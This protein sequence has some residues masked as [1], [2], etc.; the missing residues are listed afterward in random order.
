MS[1]KPLENQQILATRADNKQVA[2]C[3]LIE[4]YGAKAVALPCIDI[5]P[6]TPD[7]VGFGIAKQHILDLD[8]FDIVICISANAARIAGELIDQYWPQLP[9]KIKWLAIGSASAKELAYFDIDAQI[10]PGADSESLLAH[11]DLQ[12]VANQKVLILQGNSGRELLQQSLIERGAFISQAILY[13]RLIP[14]YT[15]QQVENSLYKSTISA[16]LVT[17]G[18]ALCN[19]TTIARGSSQQFDITSLLNTP[20]I[21]PSTRV[22]Q[23]AS[24]QGYL[25]IKVASGADD[26]SMLNALLK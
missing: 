26:S 16:I 9:V 7:Q 2:L 6:I 1:T 4:S 8:L 17:S 10:M 14:V 21:V 13:K 11:P 18:E 3:A 12:A 24:T 5:S 15:D 23:I 25:N 19:L 22:A 20:L